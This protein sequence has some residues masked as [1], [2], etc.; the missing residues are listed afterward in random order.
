MAPLPC[1]E[2]KVFRGPQPHIVYHET[3]T[4]ELQHPEERVRKLIS[5]FSAVYEKLASE[6]LLFWEFRSVLEEV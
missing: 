6:T 3:C 1:S 5:V 2:L 4:W